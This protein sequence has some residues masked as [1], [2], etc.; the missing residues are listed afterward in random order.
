MVRQRIE[1]EQVHN[2]VAWREQ[3][4]W[5]ERE[6][7]EGRID[8]L[9]VTH[10]ASGAFPELAEAMRTGRFDTVQLPYNPHEREVRAGAPA[11]RGASSAWR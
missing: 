4:A 9:G 11:A 6:R 8:R 1:I 2:L 7:D 5:L 10:Y 3:L